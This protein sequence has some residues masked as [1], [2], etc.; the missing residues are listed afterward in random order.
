MLGSMEVGTELPG[1]IDRQGIGRASIDEIHFHLWGS[2]IRI[3]RQYKN[4]YP[5]AAVFHQRDAR[6]WIFLS[7]LGDIQAING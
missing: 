2:S 3:I 4:S 5:C 1:R 6:I 7:C